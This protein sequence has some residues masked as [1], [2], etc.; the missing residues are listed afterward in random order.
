MLRELA[1]PEREAY[2]RGVQPIWGGGLNPDRFVAFQRRLADS[3]EAGRRYRLLGLFDGQHLVSAMKAYDLHG[4]YAGSPLRL[5]GIGAVYTPPPL[6]R[7][8]YAR[9]MLELAIADHRA[10]GF[11]AAL[12]F[13][14]IGGEY[15]E[16]L[17]FRPVRSDECTAEAAD[18]PRGGAGELARGDEVSLAR[19]FAQ[20]RSADGELSLARD[21]WVLSFQLRRLRELARARGAGEPEWAL[22]I[23]S[24]VGEAAAMLRVS[25]DAIEVL[26]AGWTSESLR[27][28]LLAAL[29]DFLLR[30]G[31]SRLRL[32]P[33]H[34]LRGLFPAEPRASALGMVA[35]L[36]DGVKLPAAGAAAA[37]ALLDHI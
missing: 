1:D 16:R 6:R 35:P 12:L 18:L 36:R 22:R 25:R 28:R 26:D 21:G 31:R 17:G 30:N 5:L 8:G 23:A 19:V 32:W 27:D 29:R 10:A 3:A 13:S 11:D 7:R 33:A 34:Q 20:S 4:S 15:Y 9:Q 2:F 37:F 14:D 24:G